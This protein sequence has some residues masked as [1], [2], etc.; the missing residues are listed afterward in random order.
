MASEPLTSDQKFPRLQFGTVSTIPTPNLYPDTNLSISNDLFYISL[1]QATFLDLQDAV[2]SMTPV[3]THAT[4][5][6][7]SVTTTLNLV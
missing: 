7:P 2:T 4:M 5:T 6:A 1:T 3:M